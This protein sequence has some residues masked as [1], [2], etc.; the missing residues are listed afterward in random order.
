MSA[1][2]AARGSLS[3]AD[4]YTRIFPRQV[5]NYL[6]W[7]NAS[8]TVI[9]EIGLEGPL[10]RADR[11]IPEAIAHVRHPVRARGGARSQAGP[12]FALRPVPAGTDGSA[13]RGLSGHRPDRRRQ[14][15]REGVS[16]AAT[17]LLAAIRGLI[18]GAGRFVLEELHSR[19]WAS[20]T[21]SGARHEL[22][23]RL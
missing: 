14:N 13:R 16:D 7:W 18:G 19:A 12:R 8:G 6:A 2:R 10:A 22:A 20:V 5:G 9:Q 21:F 1:A 11:A 23:F 15:M 3:I 4:L 17:A